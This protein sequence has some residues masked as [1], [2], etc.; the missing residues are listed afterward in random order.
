MNMPHHIHFLRYEG[1]KKKDKVK[2]V[3]VSWN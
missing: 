2:I 1:K 3:E